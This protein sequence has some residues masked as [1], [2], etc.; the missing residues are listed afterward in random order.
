MKSLVADHLYEINF[1]YVV[2]RLGEESGRKSAI[3]RPPLRVGKK[4]RTT[5]APGVVPYRSLSVGAF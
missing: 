2:W 1:S 3:E 5:V 4:N